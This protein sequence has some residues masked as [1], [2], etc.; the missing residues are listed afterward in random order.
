MKKTIQKDIYTRV[1]AQSDKLTEF[2]PFA[3]E[4]DSIEVTVWKNGEG[5]D[6]TISKDHHVP[7]ISLTYGEFF[8]IK[9]LVKQLDNIDWQDIPKLPNNLIPG[10]WYEK[11]WYIHSLTRSSAHIHNM[12]LKYST[13]RWKRSDFI[14]DCNTIYKLYKE[15]KTTKKKMSK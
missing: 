15:L 2:C 9:K 6:I 1:S 12:G 5:F 8:L 11:N 4:N 14:K 13:L 7:V 10:E 3:K